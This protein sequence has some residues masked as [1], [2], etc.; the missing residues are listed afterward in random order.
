MQ[1]E[2]ALEVKRQSRYYTI[3]NT[4]NPKEVWFVLHGYG[5][6]ANYF[7]KK[8]EG[9]DNGERL[10]VAPEGAH[11]FYL[12]GTRGRVGAS[13]MTKENR[14]QDIIEY[15]SFLDALYTEILASLPKETKVNVLGFSQGAATASRWVCAGN[16]IVDNLVLWAG[17]FPPDLNF[18][19]D[20]SI[21]DNYGVFLAVGNADEYISEDRL[22]EHLSVL[23]GEE[24]K[25]EVLRFKGKHEVTQQPLEELVQLIN[26]KG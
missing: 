23:D 13:W 3:G 20:K 21:L 4:V 1:K 6:L 2:A 24:L 17:V 25:Y 18:E 10:F 11:R 9:L 7:I 12:T 14:L 22:K 15:T 26:K 5:Y 19:V 8:F 16:S